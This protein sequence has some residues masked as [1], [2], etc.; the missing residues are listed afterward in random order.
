MKRGPKPVGKCYRCRLN[1]GDHCWAFA[2]P[3]L[4]WGGRKCPGFEN[5]KL[6][7]QFAEWQDAAHVKTRRQIRREKFRS[8][9]PGRRLYYSRKKSAKRCIKK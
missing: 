7:R 3:R 4:Q 9:A 1:L 5:E 8:A 6:Y 2:F